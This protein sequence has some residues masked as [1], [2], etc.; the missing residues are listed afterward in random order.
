MPHTNLGH[1]NTC[2]A[3][4]ANGEYKP[5]LNPLINAKN[6]YNN[7]EK[8][9]ND[10]KTLLESDNGTFRNNNLS[11]FAEGLS[12]LN[13]YFAKG[14]YVDTNGKLSVTTLEGSMEDIK[15]SIKSDGARVLF[16]LN[17][18]KAF[19]NK[20]EAAYIELK[21]ICTQ[22][23]TKTLGHKPVDDK[24]QHL[25][26]NT[27]V[28]FNFQDIRFGGAININARTYRN[29]VSLGTGG[30]FGSSNVSNIEK[31]LDEFNEIIKSFKLRCNNV[32]NFMGVVK[33]EDKLAL[34]LKN[35]K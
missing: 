27:M 17:D 16:I 25:L 12:L 32:D 35:K 13:Q 2:A 21:K 7:I 1:Y 6:G 8:F 18:M 5:D 19:F 29:N 26:E 23:K 34:L 15:S 14:I 33:P 3:A 4:F 28:D 30:L 9:V 24:D 22:L 31:T 11:Q 10:L 20:F